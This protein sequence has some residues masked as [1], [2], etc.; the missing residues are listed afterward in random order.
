MP[1]PKRRKIVSAFREK[2]KTTGVNSEECRGVSH[3]PLRGIVQLANFD[4][5]CFRN[6]SFTI[7]ES[8]R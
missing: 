7:N 2:S 3:P 8:L 6:W 4:A 1:T 5:L